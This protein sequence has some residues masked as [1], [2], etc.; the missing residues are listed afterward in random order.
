M[1]RPGCHGPGPNGPDETAR[2][3]RSAQRPPAA[4][5]WLLAWTLP[6]LPAEPLVAPELPLVPDPL[7]LPEADP[8]VWP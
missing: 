1:G 5:A 4:E 3:E 2:A 6:A 7:V 8:E